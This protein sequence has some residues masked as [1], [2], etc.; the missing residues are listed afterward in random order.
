MVWYVVW[1]EMDF[2]R[3]DGCLVQTRKWAR[4]QLEDLLELGVIFG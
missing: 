2:D 4:L 3:R 1:L